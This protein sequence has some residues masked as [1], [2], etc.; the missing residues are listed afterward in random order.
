MYYLLRHFKFFLQ[1]LLEL[2]YK[3]SE[4]FKKKTVHWTLMKFYPSQCHWK[5]S[6]TNKHDSVTIK[7]YSV[8]L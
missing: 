7:P 2:A 5:G 6:I 1:K 8:F 4:H 3:N